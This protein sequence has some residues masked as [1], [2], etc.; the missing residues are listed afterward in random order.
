MSALTRVLKFIAT[1]SVSLLLTACYGTIHVMYG[2]PIRMRDVAVRTVTASRQPIPELRVVLYG[3]G[4]HDEGTTN[5]QGEVL[6]ST[7]AQPPLSVQVQDLDGDDNLG[8]FAEHEEQLPSNLGAIDR[9]I[10]MST[11]E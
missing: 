2:V 1:G 10:T 9:E 11:E 5:Q 6:F 8:A 4:F 3:Q 7:D